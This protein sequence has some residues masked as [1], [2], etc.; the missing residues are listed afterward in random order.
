MPADRKRYVPRNKEEPMAKEKKTSR[1]LAEMIQAKISVGGAM[2]SVAKDPAYGWHPT[3]RYSA[4][5]SY[6]RTS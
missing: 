6:R 2:I 3:C 1:E 5:Q 4:Q